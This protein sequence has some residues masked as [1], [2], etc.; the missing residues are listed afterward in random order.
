MKHISDEL[1]E[2]I[3]NIEKRLKR[4]N[5]YE[6]TMNN[7]L[8]FLF[9]IVLLIIVIIVTMLLIRNNNK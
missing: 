9:K 6:D 4:K 1:L 2:K 8:Y 5:Q 7:T 3:E